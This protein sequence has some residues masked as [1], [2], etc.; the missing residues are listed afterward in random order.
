MLSTLKNAWHVPEL[1]KKLIFTIAMLFVF[2]VGAF[3]PVPGIDSTVLQKM[4]ANNSLAGFFDIISGGAFSYATIFAM[5]VTPYINASIILQLLTVAIPSL[6]KLSKEGQDGRKKIAEYTRYLTIVLG[7]IQSISYYIALDKMGAIRTPGIW[8]AIVIIVSFTA[9]TAFL[10]WIGEKIT[11]RGVGNGMSLLIFTGIVS[12]FPIAAM[13]L[14]NLYGIG[15][16]NVFILAVLLAAAFAVIAFVVFFDKAERRIPVQY[17]RRVVGRTAMGGQVSNMPMK[18][19]I[20]G[21]IPIIFALSITQIPTMIENFAGNNLS[22]K[23]KMIL[24]YFSTNNPVGAVLYAVLIIFFTYFYATILFNVEE[25]AE[26]MKKNGAFIPGVRQGKET[27]EF[28]A[29]TLSKLTF[30][31]AV[32]LVIVAMIPVV[33]QNGLGLNIFFGSTSLL[34]VVGVAL[35][36]V[37]QIEAQMTMR[38]YRGF[39]D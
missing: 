35:E 7:L 32:F 38:H 6:E 30:I 17:P 10:M 13:Y 25:I 2:R 34:I 1:R 26:N 28:L 24:G 15:K 18:V 8:S 5:S 12:R 3:I 14:Y 19:N 21:V 37:R 33:V 31:G 39:L 36:T 16:I 20:G 9:G 22:L 29:S 23:A 27:A 11:E 4:V